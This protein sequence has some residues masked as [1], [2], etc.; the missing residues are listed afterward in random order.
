MGKMQ[1]NICGTCGTKDSRTGLLIETKG[2]NLSECINCHDTRE[3]KEVVIH[4]RLPR[5]EEEIKKTIAILDRKEKDG[6]NNK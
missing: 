3:R 1:Y 2:T 5:T 4:M 6:T